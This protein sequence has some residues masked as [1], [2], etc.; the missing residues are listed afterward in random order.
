MSNFDHFIIKKFDQFH[1]IVEGID[2]YVES[3]YDDG[4]LS[5]LQPLSSLP[6]PPPCRKR[7]PKKTTTETSNNSSKRRP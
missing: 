6:P 5:L 4:I 1:I 2:E 7:H 3:F